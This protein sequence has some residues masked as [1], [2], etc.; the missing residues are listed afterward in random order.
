MKKP[1]T[2]G[3]G[4]LD[5]GSSQCRFAICHEASVPGGYLF[6]AEPTLRDSVYCARH[7]RIAIAVERRQ[8][9]KSIVPHLRRAS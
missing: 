1:A 4:L 8:A 5:L 6:C 2:R 7:Q 9:G 3:V